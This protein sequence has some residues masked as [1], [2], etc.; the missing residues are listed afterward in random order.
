[1]PV[2]EKVA[3]LFSSFSGIKERIKS[4]IPEQYVEAAERIAIRGGGAAAPNEH[5]EMGT[6]KTFERP[7]GTLGGPDD[8]QD[9]PGNNG[10]GN[11]FLFNP[12]E[13]SGEIDPHTGTSGKISAWQ[14]GW[15]VT[16]A[17]QVGG[18]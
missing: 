16:N 15:N 12:N 17:I 4:K 5:H 8:Y 18:M 2:D 13:T 9:Y 3:S 10:S 11:P 1:M 7:D 14:A 6:F